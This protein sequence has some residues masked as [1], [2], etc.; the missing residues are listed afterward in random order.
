MKWTAA[1]G[2]SV[3]VERRAS[4]AAAAAAHVLPSEAPVGSSARPVD[5]PKRLVRRASLPFGRG[6]VRFTRTTLLFPGV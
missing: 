2:L 4:A 3:P 5:W 1:A 6:T